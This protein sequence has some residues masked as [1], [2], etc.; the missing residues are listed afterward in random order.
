MFHLSIAHTT[1]YNK[2]TVSMW[3]MKNNPPFQ[4]SDVGHSLNG[5]VVNLNVQKVPRYDIAGMC[6]FSLL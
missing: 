2:V 3:H 1:L 5:P 6:M 4:E